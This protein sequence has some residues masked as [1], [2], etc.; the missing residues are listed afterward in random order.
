MFFYLL[1]ILI[2]NIL[3]YSKKRNCINTKYTP[4]EIFGCCVIILV[5]ILRF[6]VG[7]DYYHYFEAIYPTI[8]EVAINRY[9]PISKVIMLTGAALKFPQFVFIVFGLINYL[10]IIHICHKYS[11]NFYLAILTFV[12][13]FYLSSLGTIRQST[14]VAITIGGFGYVKNKQ[15]VKYAIICIIASLFHSTAAVSILVYFL[16][17]YANKWTVPLMAVL[18]IACR[19]FLWNLIESSS[20]AR[21]LDILEDMSGGHLKR[22]VNIAW[23]IVLFVMNIAIRNR[24]TENG[25]VYSRLFIITI[26]GAFMPFVF[27]SFFGGRLGEYFM[28]YLCLLVPFVISK[29][30]KLVFQLFA[31]ILSLYFMVNIYINTNSLEG[32]QYVPYR[33]YLFED[34]NHSQFR[35]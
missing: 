29:Y 34:I 18:A 14:A 23:L 7:F 35:R 19:A 30:N 8:D 16:Y 32:V 28:V 17:N 9:E 2:I 13:F 4:K 20:Y 22:I 26:F 27:G 24:K 1:F 6:D 31:L 33:S 15:F 5:S 11:E 3:L 10:I 25:V 21:Y 12:A